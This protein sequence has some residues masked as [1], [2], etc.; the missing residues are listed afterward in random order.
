[1]SEPESSDGQQ[2]KSTTEPEIVAEPE[3]VA[4]PEKETDGNSHLFAVRTTGGQEKIVMRLLEARIK[5][6][7]I[8]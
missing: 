1:M 2:A 8:R 5:M 4:E 3:T 7:K 6:E